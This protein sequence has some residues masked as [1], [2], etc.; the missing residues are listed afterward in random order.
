MLPEFVFYFTHGI[1]KVK[2]A[3]NILEARGMDR[4]LSLM[5]SSAEGTEW[6]PQ[7]LAL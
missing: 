3:E 5:S 4:V 6:D 7:P 2:N 1:L